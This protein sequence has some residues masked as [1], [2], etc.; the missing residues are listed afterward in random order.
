MKFTRWNSGAYVDAMNF[1]ARPS[2]RHEPGSHV[3]KGYEFYGPI[4]RNQSIFAVRILKNLVVKINAGF[5]E[6]LES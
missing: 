3:V 2:H 5:N 4:V 6:T 1:I